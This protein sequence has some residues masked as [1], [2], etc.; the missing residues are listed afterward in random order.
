LSADVEADARHADFLVDG[1]VAESGRRHRELKF[2]GLPAEAGG[3]AWSNMHDAMYASAFMGMLFAPVIVAMLPGRS[4]AEARTAVTFLRR[5]TGTRGGAGGILGDD[6][7]F[8][9]QPTL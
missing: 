9:I 2:T 6:A 5:G 3:E 1:A 7:V 4:G 8:H